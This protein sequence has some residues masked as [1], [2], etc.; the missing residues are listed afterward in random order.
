MR[1]DVRGGEGG[2]LQRPEASSLDSM[3]KARG[4]VVGEQ[5]R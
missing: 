2:V 1:R 5:S 3:R 4:E